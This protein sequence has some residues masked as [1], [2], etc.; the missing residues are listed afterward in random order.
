MERVDTVVV[1]G[2][3]AGL[4]LSRSLSER[5]VEHVVLERGRVG[6]RWRSERWDSLSLLTPRWLSRL[7]GW[8]GDEEDPHGFMAREEVVRYLDRYAATFGVPVREGVT[9]TSVEREG[10]DYRVESNL[11]AWRASNVVVAT[12]ESQDAFVPSMSRDLASW[13]HQSAPTRYRN[14]DHLP[15]GGVLVVG[16]S[17]TGIQL[18]QEIHASGRPVTLSVS[19]H[20][21]L[22]RRYRERDILEWLERMGMFEQ[23]AAEVQSLEASRNQPSMQLTGS[24]DHRT[25]DL[26]VLQGQGIRLVGRAE[27]ASGSRM[28]FADDL[29]E[30]MAAADV[31]L[32]GLRLR[33]DRYI[34]DEGLEREVG[35]EEPF[36]P[37][38]L[39][40]APTSLDL[41]TQ[42]I[43][44]VLWA[45]GFRRSYPW[46]RVPVLDA[47][48]EIRQEGGITSAAGLYVLGLNFM[49]RRSSS[50]LAGVARDAE[51]IA[52]HM[53]RT[54]GAG[55]RRR[56]VA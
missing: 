4:A 8:T 9:V 20:T 29:V 41:R 49:R 47:G 42:G 55:R 50:F 16:A 18:A 37:M 2:G 56:A 6:E 12:G 54:R 14:P 44:S 36:D 10:D 27:G 5:G 43:K 34:R 45:T 28:C 35:P 7:S 17:A 38:P 51:E 1:G 39:P 40:D 3:Q 30:T 46:L 21:R 23:R 48:G 32:A 53:V 11:G 19:R 24:A 26:K 25:L 33:I 31:K 15:E 22:P 52:E 13:V